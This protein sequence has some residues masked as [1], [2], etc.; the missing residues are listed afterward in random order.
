MKS[1]LL[2]SV[3]VAVLVSL[4]G[5]QQNTTQSEKRIFKAETEG[6][7]EPESSDWVKYITPLREY[8]YYRT[9]AVV[10]KD[11]TILWGRYPD[12]KDNINLK[13]GVNAEG[14]EVESLNQS[15]DLIDANYNIESYERIKVKRINDSEAAVLM[16][17]SIIYLGNDFDETGGEYVIEVFLEHRDN[18]WT[19]V[20]TDEYTLPEYKEWM[21]GQE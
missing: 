16:H 13:Q 2:R 19:V 11:T 5:C 7:A 20:K 8:M 17:G 10:N 21:N 1:V 4:A 18:H 3:M 14:N 15:F 9:Q 12:L 6:F